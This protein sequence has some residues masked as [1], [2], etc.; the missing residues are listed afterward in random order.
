MSNPLLNMLSSG[1]NNTLF[2]KISPIIGLLKGDTNTVINSLL[3]SN[4]EA[5]KAWSMVQQ[6]TKGKNNKEIEKIAEDL[7]KQNGVSLSELKGLLKK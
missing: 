7:A 1:S 3:N 2:S 4:P 5:K 6:M